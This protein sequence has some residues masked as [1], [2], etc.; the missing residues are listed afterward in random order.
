MR[1]LVTDLGTFEKRDGEL[2]LT[3]LAPGAT[4]DDVRALCGWDLRVADGELPVLDP[5]TADEVAALRRWDPARLVPPRLL[6]GWTQRVTMT[7]Q[8]LAPR[9]TVWASPTRA[10]ST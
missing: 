6:A 5:P 4:V 7:Q 1:A 2:V 10:P 8:A 3:A 9:P